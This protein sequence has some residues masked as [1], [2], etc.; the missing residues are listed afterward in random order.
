MSIDEGPSRT[1]SGLGLGSPHGPGMLGGGP[2]GYGG[3]P[4][5]DTDLV[6]PPLPAQAQDPAQYDY[7]RSNRRRE[8]GGA[9]GA[10]TRNVSNGWGG[11]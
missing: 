6:S 5:T 8:T 2:Y 9:P 4:Q 7:F 1:I 10:A 3:L 11:N